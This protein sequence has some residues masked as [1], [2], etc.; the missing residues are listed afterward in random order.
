VG[1]AIILMDYFFILLIGGTVCGGGGV[2]V[3]VCVCVRTLRTMSFIM[4]FRV[5]V[6]PCVSCVSM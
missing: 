1:S 3:C 5:G 4:G 2:G 6:M